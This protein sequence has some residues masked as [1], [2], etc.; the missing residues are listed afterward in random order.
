MIER[1]TAGAAPAGRCIQLHSPDA[2]P[3]P[4]P[5]PRGVCDH[6]AVRA[7][8]HPDATRRPPRPRPAL[9]T[10]IAALAAAALLLLA[11]CDRAVEG[12]ARPD[13]AV[14]APAGLAAYYGQTLAWGSCLPFAV[15]PD[16]KIAYA[17]PSLQCTR[18]RVPL[19]YANPG[20]R[21]AQIAVLRHRA[22]SPD[23]RIG[24]LVVNPGGPGASGV[25]T[26]AALTSAVIGTELGARFDLVGFDPRGIGASTPTVRCLTGPEQDADRRADD[27]DPSP[28]G[29]AASE[30]EAKRS[31]AG[32]VARTG[33]DVLAT[34]GTRDVARDMD[35]LRA[36]L[37]DRGLNYLGYSYGT[38]IGSTYAEEFPANVRAMVLDGALDPDAD[39]TDEV[40]AQ[41]RGFQ[42][43]FDAFARDCATHPDCPL[44]TDPTAATARYQ[45]LTRPLITRQLSLADGRVLSYSDAQQGTIQALYTESAWPTL[46]QGLSDLAAGRGGALMDLADQYYDRGADGQYS[47]EQD[48]FN[49]VR[50]VDDPRLDAPAQ[51]LDRATRYDAAAPF[52]SSGRG[53]SAA[54]DECAFWPVPPT[55]RPHLPQVPGLRAPLVVSTTGDPAT[56]YQAG[57]ELAAALK[58]S[59]L[60]KVGDQH[61]AT[62]QGFPC[63]DAIVT[64]YLVDGTPAASGATCPAQ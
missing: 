6:R 15:T 43:A 25:E 45:Q 54:R 39:P 14:G 32:C 58:G 42:G 47:P 3:G 51:A 64:R 46:R 29:V 19:D 38:R 31:V 55:S 41:G 63:V 36:A 27:T 48:A 33:D 5:G 62:L 13:P 30:D 9:V 61:T 4:T 50:C 56:P 44:G 35:V 59:L 12:Q 18:L 21:D 17:D 1:V 11:G 20:G 37:G 34:I 53:P 52:L 49:A 60:T 26:A 57:V 2:H 40:V 28:A 22:S 10:A 24:S 7:A 16:Q 8:D 23:R